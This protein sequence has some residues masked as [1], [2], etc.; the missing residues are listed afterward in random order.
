[1]MVA[2]AALRSS[3]AFEAQPPLAAPDASINRRVPVGAPGRL[4]ISWFEELM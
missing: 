2:L 4:G 1:M 3:L